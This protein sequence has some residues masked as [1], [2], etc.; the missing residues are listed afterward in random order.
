MYV[1]TS[2]IMSTLEDSKWIQKQVPQVQRTNVL[3]KFDHEK[4]QMID[5]RCGQLTALK[6]SKDGTNQTTTTT[7]TVASKNTSKTNNTQGVNNN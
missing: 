7:T 5:L 3:Q 2:D 4:M 6:N 1:G